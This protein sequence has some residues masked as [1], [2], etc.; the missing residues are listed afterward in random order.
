MKVETMNSQFLLSVKRILDGAWRRRYLLCLPFLLMLP[1]AVLMALYGPKVYVAKSLM[2]LQESGSTNPLSKDT[3]QSG[4]M[5]DRIAGLQALLKSDRVLVSVYRDVMGDQVGGPAQTAAWVRDFAL[6][7]SLELIGA[8]FLEFQLKG[9]NPK[10]MGKR[11][12]TVTARFLDALLPEQNALFASQVL[13]EKRKEDLESAEKVLAAFRQRVAE[14]IPS[15]L[16]QLTAQIQEMRS[17][18]QG[19]SGQLAEINGEIIAVRARLGGAAIVAA[20][21]A[22]DIVQVRGEI[23]AIEARGLS[24]SVEMQ[25]AK[26][27]LQSLVKLQSLEADR[28]TL[29]DEIRGLG[30][31]IDAL[32]RTAKQ[33]EPLTTRITQLERDV[34][35]A[36]EAYEVYARRYQRSAVSKAGGV[37]NAPERIKLIDAPRDPEFPVTSGTRLAMAG[38]L[39]SIV[40]GLGLALGAEM[41]DQLVRRPEDL[42][43]VTGLPIVARLS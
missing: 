10:G 42:E 23:T 13:L 9:A 19:K 40:L 18:M 27:R 24:A 4:R 41:L 17:I 32:L 21:L 14:Q 36:K 7:V 16:P 15:G 31:N 22:Q 3:G 1:A 29:D 25:A 39:A 37:L 38:L 6:Q 5:Q 12:E 2:L 30:R 26:L 20:R 11:L 8:D 33:S 28:S 43:E 34:A 35:E